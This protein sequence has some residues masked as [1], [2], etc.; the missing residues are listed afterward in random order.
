MCLTVCGCACS[1]GT[2]AA[3]MIART[4]LINRGSV[5]LYTDVVDAPE[6]WPARTRSAPFGS[7]TKGATV[8]E[9]LDT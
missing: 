4:I 8:H 2:S 3:S 9:L 5:P 1:T 7:A 6:R